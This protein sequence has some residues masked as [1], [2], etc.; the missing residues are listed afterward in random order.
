MSLINN[1]IFGNPTYEQNTI[2]NLYSFLDSSL[3]EIKF[4]LRKPLNDSEQTKK[5]IEKL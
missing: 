2:K 3:E 4:K 1:V 5:E